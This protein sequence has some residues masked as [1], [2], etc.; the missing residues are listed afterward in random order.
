[1]SSVQNPGCLGYIGDY[2]TQVYGDYNIGDVAFPKNKW[3]HMDVSLNGGFSP[4]II[5][6]NKGLPLFS[7]SILGGFPLF[8]ETP[9]WKSS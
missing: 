9:T 3:K 5:L 4:Q 1:M 2:T 6:F 8:L 7:P